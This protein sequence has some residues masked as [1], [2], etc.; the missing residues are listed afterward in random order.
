ML[1]SGSLPMSSAATTSLIRFC[2]CLISAAAARL[3]LKP[4]VTVK[5]SSVTTSSFFSASFLAASAVTAGVVWA[6]AKDVA[7]S[8]SSANAAGYR[9][10]RREG[11]AELTECIWV[12][13]WE[14]T[15]PPG[16]EAPGRQGSLDRG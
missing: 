6:T 5:A 15:L 11:G 3:P 13:C 7:A 10:A 12:G 9:R 8:E 16:T 2:F 4:L 14:K 1:T